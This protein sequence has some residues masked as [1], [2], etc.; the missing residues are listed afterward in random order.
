M[1]GRAPLKVDG[2]KTAFERKVEKVS[3]GVHTSRPKKPCGQVDNNK[4]RAAQLEI[5]EYLN[6]HLEYDDEA[7]TALVSSTG[8]HQRSAR[9]ADTLHGD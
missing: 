7:E 2:K 8:A 4:M 6:F 9:S 1:A 5:S 3:A